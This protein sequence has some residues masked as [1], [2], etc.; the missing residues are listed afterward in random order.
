MQDTEELPFIHTQGKGPDSHYALPN[1]PGIILKG[2]LFSLKIYLGGFFL[3]HLNFAK[4]LE[5][6]LSSFPLRL[7][8]S[9]ASHQQQ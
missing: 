5:S 4:I 7:W 3:G 6:F 9:E 2:L 1:N 8:N